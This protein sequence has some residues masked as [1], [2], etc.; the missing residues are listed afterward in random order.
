MESLRPRFL[1]MQAVGAYLRGYSSAVE[2]FKE[3]FDGVKDKKAVYEIAHQARQFFCSKESYGKAFPQ[4]SVR[5]L[6]Q[7]LGR[8]EQIPEVLAACA[9]LRA[10]GLLP[11][12]REENDSI[13][14]TE[15][16]THVPP[17][18]DKMVFNAVHGMLDD[19]LA[20]YS[21]YNQVGVECM[22]MCLDGESAGLLEHIERR[23]K[24]MQ[25]TLLLARFPREGAT[26]H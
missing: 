12:V 9:L 22:R 13:S 24:E 15:I 25:E 6:A 17:L 19:S 18:Y 8:A 10:L 5:D 26:V 23:L 1:Q 16:P 11:D 2:F 3:K 20:E 14:E 4:C 21:W 7:W